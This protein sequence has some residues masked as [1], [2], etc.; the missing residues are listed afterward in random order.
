MSKP[1]P[2][3]DNPNT[4]LI[5][6]YET[7]G[8]DT[9]TFPLNQLRTSGASKASPRLAEVPGMP[10][11]LDLDGTQ[12]LEQGPL[13]LEVAYMVTAAAGTTLYSTQSEIEQLTARPGKLWRV[14]PNG[15]CEWTRARRLGT[16]R[17]VAAVENL[18]LGQALG[19]RGDDI[20]LADLLEERVLGEQGR[21]REGADHQGGFHLPGFDKIVGHAQRINKARADGL[22]IKRRNAGPPQGRLHFHLMHQ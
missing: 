20:L 1:D 10:G 15:R 7:D 16:P 11:A 2:P 18:A 9:C 21:G 13:E 22:H 4:P 12:E 6:G 3:I 14:L 5:Y 17:K 8:G 19:P